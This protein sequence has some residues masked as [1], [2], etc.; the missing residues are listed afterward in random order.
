MRNVY[1]VYNENCILDSEIQ[2][3]NYQNFIEK[4]T[5]MVERLPDM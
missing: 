3:D 4:G 2:I 5:E 1:K